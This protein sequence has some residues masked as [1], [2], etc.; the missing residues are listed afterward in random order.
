MRNFFRELRNCE[1]AVLSEDA[2]FTNLAGE[3][4]PYQ[5]STKKTLCE[6]ISIVSSGMFFRTNSP[7]YFIVKNFR[8][9]PSRLAALW[10]EKHPD[11]RKAESTWRSQVYS[12]SQKFFRLFGDDF[13]QVFVSQNMD[14]IERIRGTLALLS[15]PELESWELLVGEVDKYCEGYQGD[16]FT[17][18]E[19]GKELRFL[20]RMLRCRLIPEMEA[21]DGCKLQYLKWVLDKPVLNLQD[22]SINR[23][24][25]EALSALGVPQIILGKSL[26]L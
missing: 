9:G 21:L 23:D 20:R 11:D 24:K 2:L 22:F 4:E 3:S 26:K 25:V 18:A 17:I 13:F 12:V 7:S 19:C 10:N 6:V 1:E 14:G 16:N 15:I 5:E 8:L